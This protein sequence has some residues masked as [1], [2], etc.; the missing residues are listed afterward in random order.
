MGG[1]LMSKSIGGKKLVIYPILAGFLCVAAGLIGLLILSVSAGPPRN[2]G[3]RNGRLAACPASPN[4][5]STQ[6][7]DQEHWIA[8]LNA[9][10]VEPDPL[11]LLEEI[12]R[13]MDRA[14]V[15]ERSNDYL[16][17][18]FRSL[19]F[20]F[21]DDV[22]FFHESSSGRIHFRSASRVGYSD[23]GVNRRRMEEIRGKFQQK[24]PRS[25]AA[26]RASVPRVL[27]FR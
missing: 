6:S 5:V 1:S 26:P 14:T 4:C 16:R 12:V 11:Q 21:C 27:S 8:P 18:E 20:R 17:V 10:F 19:L 25:V 15:V 24:A 13:G 23:L 9:G 3:V 22:E 7:E 2:S